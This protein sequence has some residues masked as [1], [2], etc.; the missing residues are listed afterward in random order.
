MAIARKAVECIFQGH[1]H[2]LCVCVCVCV[3][4][5]VGECVCVCVCVYGGGGGLQP[6]N[7]FVVTRRSGIFW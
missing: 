7:N 3:C 5:F 2:S 1:H 4:V 6:P